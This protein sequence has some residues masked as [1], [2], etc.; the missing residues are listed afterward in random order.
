M[1]NVDHMPQ[2]NPRTIAEDMDRMN[3]RL[4]DRSA[5]N[6]TG[7]T[8]PPTPPDPENMEKVV[9][10]RL[11]A[12][13]ELGILHQGQRLYPTRTTGGKETRCR[14]AGAKWLLAFLSVKHVKVQFA[15]AGYHKAPQPAQTVW[16]NVSFF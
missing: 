11:T 4:L 13:R 12:D 1:G 3:A 8:P 7:I 2:S 9:R 14:G 6:P 10:H 15:A 16:E 5:T